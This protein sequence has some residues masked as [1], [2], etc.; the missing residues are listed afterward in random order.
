MLGATGC[1]RSPPHLGV[2]KTEDAKIKP[3]LGDGREQ[4]WQRDLQK[5]R[6][7][8]FEEPRGDIKLKPRNTGRLGWSHPYSF[9]DTPLELEKMELAL[10]RTG[11]W[12]R[13]ATG[14]ACE[15]TRIG[16]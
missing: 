8:L 16:M 13:P 12:K 5:Q 6:L 14:G 15:H 3:E 7:G 11:C 1:Q 9:M 2:G 10:Q 4:G